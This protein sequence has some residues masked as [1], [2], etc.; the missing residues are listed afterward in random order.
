MALV[1]FTT[2]DDVRAALGVSSDE[3]EDSTLSL[4][5]YEFNLKRE[6]RE[7]AGSLPST[8]ATVA[9]A[10][11]R[12]DAQTQLFE[13]VRLFST[14]AV[15]WHL[16]ASLPMFSPKEVT[17]SKASFSRYAAGTLEETISRVEMQYGTFKA[18]VQASLTNLDA[19]APQA[20]AT[21]LTH[22]VR[23]GLAQDPVTG[24]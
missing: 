7:L 21:V 17:D 14:Y 22:A 11:Q 6:L 12:T 10:T 1:D 23:V 2:F 20:V 24:S 3:L 8:Y 5:V 19:A 9:A 4:A 13:S 15:A 18:Y 16:C